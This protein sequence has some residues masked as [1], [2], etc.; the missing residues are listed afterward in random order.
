MLTVS[1]AA[2]TLADGDVFAPF[3]FHVMAKSREGVNERKT[4]GQIWR[5][6][7]FLLF[8]IDFPNYMFLFMHMRQTDS[9]IPRSVDSL[10]T[11]LQNKAVNPFAAPD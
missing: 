6:Y 2:A 9:E 1:R 8:L 7:T 5:H 10:Q 3:Y 4:N 11:S